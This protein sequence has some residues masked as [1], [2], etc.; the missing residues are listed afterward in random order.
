MFWRTNRHAEMLAAIAG[1]N[2]RVAAMESAIL[3][4]IDHVEALE[5]RPRV[6]HVLNAWPADGRHV[7]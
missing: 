4:L 1:L 2:V 6:A 3:M 7:Q 5:Q